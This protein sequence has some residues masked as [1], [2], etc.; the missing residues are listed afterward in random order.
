MQKRLGSKIETEGAVPPRVLKGVLEEGSFCDDELSAEYFGGVLASSRSEISRDDRGVYFISLVS[1]LTTYQI[2]THYFLYNLVKMLFDGI[3]VGI[4]SS[5][6]WKLQTFIPFPSYS[7]AMEFSPKEKPYI[8]LQHVMFGLAKEGLIEPDFLF[9]SKEN[10]ISNYRGTKEQITKA[11][12]EESGN[13]IIFMPSPLG[14]ELFHWAY[15]KGDI[16]VDDFLKPEIKFHSDTKIKTLPGF[17]GIW[18]EINKEASEPDTKQSVL[19]NIP[20]T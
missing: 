16:P 2:R 15:G 20:Q 6:R 3:E 12:E 5:N 13:G 10:L 18:K 11:L 17:K 8:I 4:A 9:G 7:V 14:V 1:R 19:P